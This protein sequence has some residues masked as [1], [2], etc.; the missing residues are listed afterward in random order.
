MNTKDVIKRWGFE[1]TLNF[2]RMSK[3]E[4][5]RWKVEIKQNQPSVLKMFCLVIAC[6]GG[7]TLIALGLFFL[8]I[9]SSSTSWAQ[10]LWFTAA[11]LSW[12]SVDAYAVNCLSGE[13]GDII[14]SYLRGFFR[15]T[16]RQSSKVNEDEDEEIENGDEENPVVEEEV[17][18]SP[19]QA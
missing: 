14:Y 6:I 7:T 15:S 5:A 3:E 1:R 13:D 8:I 18:S 10:W 17:V 12:I 11:M 16:S 2:L 9:N 19:M 4:K